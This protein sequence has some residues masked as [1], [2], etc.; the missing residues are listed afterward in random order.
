MVLITIVMGVYKPT[1]ITGGPHSVEFWDDFDNK[2]GRHPVIR[3]E[4]MERRY[5]SDFC[6]NYRWTYSFE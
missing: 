6:N 3:I 1:N 2:G 5:S 4:P